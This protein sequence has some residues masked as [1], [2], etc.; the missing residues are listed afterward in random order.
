MMETTIFILLFCWLALA[1]L[2]GG[3]AARKNRSVAG[4]FLLVLLFP[5]LILPLLVLPRRDPRDRDSV[6]MDE[7]FRAQQ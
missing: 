1:S 6:T 3:L 2:A 4:W 7:L 5:F